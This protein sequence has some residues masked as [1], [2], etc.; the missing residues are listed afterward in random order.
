MV[1]S[2][3]MIGASESANPLQCSAGD[4]SL[5][6][7]H[8]SKREPGHGRNELS[9]SSSSSKSHVMKPDELARSYSRPAWQFLPDCW[10]KTIRA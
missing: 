10:L 2:H 5:S 8:L 3:R 9:S 7:R 1:F 4:L 6:G